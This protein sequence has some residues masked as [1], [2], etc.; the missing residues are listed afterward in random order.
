MAKLGLDKS[1]F[2]RGMD[3]AA[4]APDKTG[5]KFAAMG[6]AAKAGF[7]AAGAAAVAF[8]AS[9]VKTGMTF[10][11]SMSQVAAT[12]GTTTDEIG[13][14]R[15]FALE[16]GRTTA[17]SATEASEALNYMALAGYDAKTSM[18][19]LPNV[20]SMAAA[21]NMDLAKASDIAT[22]A[23]SA[24]GLSGEETKTMIDQ[25][26]KASSKSNTSIEQLGEAFLTV[27]GTAK[28]MAGGTQEMSTALGILANAG[29]KGSEGGT[30]LRNTLLGLQSG[31]FEKV[32]GAL[33]VEA[34]DAD[35]NLRPLNETMADMQKAMDGMTQEERDKTIAK[36]FN[37][38]DLKSINALLA[39]TGEAWNDLSGAIGD[40]Q[41]AAEAMADTQLDNLQGQVTLLKSAFEGLQIAIS[42]KITPLLRPIVENVSGA[43]SKITELI[44]GGDL[45]GAIQE[46]ISKLPEMIP[47][48]LEQ[49]LPKLVEFSGK[50]REKAGEL[51]GVGLEFI[52]NLAKGIM[53]GLPAIIQN[54]P[55]I[56]SNL[57]GIIND[58]APKLIA[59]GFNILV[60]IG[61][62]IIQ[63]VPVLLQNF[64]KII[65]SIFDVFM[66]ISWAGI[67][68]FVVRGIANGI[69]AL[70]GLV[71][72]AGRRL[73]TAGM[74]AITNGFKSAR[75]AGANMVRA[76][77]QAISNGA[78][79]VITAARRMASRAI[80]AVKSGFSNIGDVGM[81][82]VRGIW[83]G[84]SNGLGWI[85]AK[86]A[87]WVGNVKSFLKN[88]FGIKSPSRWARDEIGRNIVLGMAGGITSNAKM[89]DDAMRTLI[90]DTDITT[91]SVN[92]RFEGV[93]AENFNKSMADIVPA[94]TDGIS[95]AMGGVKVVLNSREFGR[96]TRK[97]VNGAI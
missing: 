94:I 51:V 64:P 32:F 25:M 57:A 15:D 86:I 24:L 16:M 76:I 83:N 37:R 41:G 53:Q 2:D 55:T 13:D 80:Q 63:A 18:E 70:V 97:A 71:R 49:M 77:G 9:S 52:K 45:T 39:N 21:G 42:D 74:K 58:N 34:Y 43:I 11:A 28:S 8:G 95:D 46:K 59:A 33:G 66:A 6:K 1:D 56:L 90:P 48:Y 4:K 27:G 5:G 44:Q 68:K 92:G 73:A 26:A 87:G 75:Q 17:F 7:A 69:K 3:E 89:I 84:I 36:V 54:V 19:M 10:D 93:L 14:L 20:L 79:A 72:G 35:G 78:H 81:N 30:A 29:I 67:G 12:M 88:L 91:A 82:L 85:K 60:T 40:S 22:D 96:M 65:K 23:Q 31:K 38:R 47:Q 50:I 61:K 62:G